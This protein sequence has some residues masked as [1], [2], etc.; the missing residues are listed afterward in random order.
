MEKSFILNDPLGFHA[1]PA[2]VV[3]GIFAK[4]QSKVSIT[5]K[6]KTVDG[7]SILQVLSLG[8]KGGD[9]VIISVEGPD[10]DEVFANV[11][12]KA[13]ESNPPLFK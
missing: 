4:A 6:G 2:A 1:R 8:V 11:L 7:K 12:Q 13:S 10:A 3:V 5:A 9:E